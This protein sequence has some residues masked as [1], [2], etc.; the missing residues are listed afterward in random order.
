MI[1]RVDPRLQAEARTF[2]LRFTCEDCAHFDPE[3][4]RCGNGFPTAPHREI[5]LQVQ[6]E[7]E[8]CK[9]FELT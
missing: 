6:R 2:A 5:D 3:L 9:G 1:T 8:F 7:L 4:A